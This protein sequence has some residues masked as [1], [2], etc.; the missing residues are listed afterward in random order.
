MTVSDTSEASHASLNGAR[1]SMGLTWTTRVAQLSLAAAGA[2]PADPP[3][4]RWLRTDVRRTVEPTTNV[5][6]AVRP[7]PPRLAP[8]PGAHRE[9]R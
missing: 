6:S 3:S 9:G 7:P 4:C 1:R 8:P 2:P 5:R